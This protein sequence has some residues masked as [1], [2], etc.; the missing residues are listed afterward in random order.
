MIFKIKTF[1]LRSHTQ[2]YYN[3]NYI[4]NHLC[5]VKSSKYDS[6]ISGFD[7]KLD[8]IVLTKV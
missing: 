4:Y 5:K 3:T 6:L 1:V 2:N 7:S 8:K